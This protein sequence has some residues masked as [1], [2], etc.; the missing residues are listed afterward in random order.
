MRWQLS[1]PLQVLAVLL[2]SLVFLVGC[3]LIPGAPEPLGTETPSPTRTPLV[4]PTLSPSPAPT[5][6]PAPTFPPYTTPDWFQNAFTYEIFVRSFADTDG[7]GVGDLRGITENLAYL[8]ALRVEVIWLMPIYPSPSVHGYDVTDYRAVNPDYGTLEDLQELV[9]EAHKREMKVILDFVPSHLSDQH[10][11][12][13]DA[14]QDPESPYSEW[15]VWTDEAHTSYAGFAGSED[16]PRFNHYN[17]EVVE[18]LTGVALTWMDLDDDGDYTDGID[19]FRIDNATFPPIEFFESFRREV[20]AANPEV[21]LLGEAWVEDVYSLSR[22]YEHR[23]DAL[24]D[25]PLYARLQGNHNFNADG[26]LAGEGAPALLTILFQEE[27]EKY[28]PEAMAVRFLSNHDTNRIATEIGG[29]PARKRLAPSLLAA[30]PGPVMVYY[31]E[32]IGMLGQKGGPPD[33]DNY[34]R[35]PMDWYAAE[36]GRYQTTWFQPLDRWNQPLDSISVEEQEDQPDSLLNFY[37]N[38]FALRAEYPA[39]QNGTFEV[40]DLDASGGGTWGFIRS[41]QEESILVLVNFSEEPRNVSFSSD[42]LGSQDGL[43]LLTGEPVVV[44]ENELS[45]ELSPASAAWVLLAEGD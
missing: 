44:S 26:L 8:E 33:W 27:T 31:G 18:Y 10:P 24:F 4:S 45:L 22:F 34:R 7:D 14:Y 36:E 2:G 21:L 30:L 9:S 17:P 15:F 29:D 6:T 25:F 5:A 40:V 1:R 35:E 32:E 28:P 3:G 11:Y 38:T 39:L 13:Q 12:F 43:D 20:K 23:F 16:M 37:R 19:G 42:L 41:A